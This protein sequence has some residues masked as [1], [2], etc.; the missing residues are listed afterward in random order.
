MSL[1]DRRKFYFSKS[2][3]RLY[4]NFSDGLYNN[5]LF[6]HCLSMKVENV[7]RFKVFLNSEVIQIKIATIKLL[8][9]NVDDLSFLEGLIDDDESVVET[10][11]QVLSK[12]EEYVELMAKM[13]HEDSVFLSSIIMHLKKMKR[14]EFLTTLLFSSNDELVSFV[15][16]I[17][18]ND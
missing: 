10:I 18:E 7:E 3:D 15:K 16:R 13:L 8:A 12:K 1:F 11:I 9:N 5:N 4:K 6:R 14:E 17:V 2:V